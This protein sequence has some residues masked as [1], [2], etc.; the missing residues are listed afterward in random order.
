MELKLYLYVDESGISQW[1]VYDSMDSF[2]NGIVEEQFQACY[3]DEN[4]NTKEK[5]RDYINNNPYIELYEI[6]S[7]EVIDKY[8]D[9]SKTETTKV[10]VKEILKGKSNGEY[11]GEELFDVFKEIVIE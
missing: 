4:F 3:E 11:L 9:D 6:N 7:N 10:P 8:I 1:Y 2:Y 5:V